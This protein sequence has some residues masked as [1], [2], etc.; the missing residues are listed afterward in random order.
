MKLK[1]NKIFITTKGHQEQKLKIKRIRI[2]VEIQ[3][4]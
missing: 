3:T 2:E 4:T 1:K